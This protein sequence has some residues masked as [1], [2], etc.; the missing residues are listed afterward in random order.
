MIKRNFSIAILSACSGS[1][2]AEV[3][4]AF[5]KAAQG[6]RKRTWQVSRYF[7]D[8]ID[9]D[10]FRLQTQHARQAAS[11]AIQTKKSLLILK[12]NFHEC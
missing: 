5:N 8:D 11:H 1:F 4:A 2:H 6:D 7:G 12:S 3:F 9:M 10:A